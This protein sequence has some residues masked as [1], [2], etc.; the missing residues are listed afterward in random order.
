MRR[1]GPV[2]RADRAEKARQMRADQKPIVA[3]LDALDDENADIAVANLGALQ[4]LLVVIRRTVAESPDRIQ[5]LSRLTD[6]AETVWSEIRTAKSLI[7]S[8]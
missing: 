3:L 4:D 1:A 7:P 6:M 8:T 5:A 2:K